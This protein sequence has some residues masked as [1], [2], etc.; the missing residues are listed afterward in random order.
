MEAIRAHEE[1]LHNDSGAMCDP[2]GAAGGARG[3]RGRQEAEEDA[4]ARGRGAE[5]TVFSSLSRRHLA[6]SR[7][8]KRKCTQEGVISA[9]SR[10]SQHS[11]AQIKGIRYVSHPLRPPVHHL[12]SLQHSRASLSQRK[13]S[14]SCQPLTDLTSAFRR[15]LC[16]EA[17]CPCPPGVL[18]HGPGDVRH[19]SE[20]GGLVHYGVKGL[21]FSRCPH[22]NLSALRSVNY[23]RPNRTSIEL[24]VTGES[25]TLLNLRASMVHVSVTVSAFQPLV[26][27]SRDFTLEPIT[28]LA[29]D[30]VFLSSLSM[31]SSSV[32][33]FHNALLPT[34]Y[35]QRPQPTPPPPRSNLHP[36]HTLLAQ[37]TADPCCVAV[38]GG[39]R[40]RPTSAQHQDTE[41]FAD[42]D[43]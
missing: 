3:E 37:F 24:P 7:C 28:W 1:E 22:S 4:P 17:G 35:H 25:V 9:L 13:H 41:Q 2:L 40:V 42:D 34:A 27:K 12:N 10:I 39:R 23:R 19:L 14:S 6:W 36:A 30:L 20:S 26:H 5:I 33:L 15:M 43:I 8:C 31:V 11:I 29:A 16:H 21:C 38:D 18:V 32:L